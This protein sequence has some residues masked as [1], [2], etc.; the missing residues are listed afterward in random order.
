M[1]TRKGGKRVGDALYW[2]G[3]RTAALSALIN[4]AGQIAPSLLLARGG[5]GGAD[6]GRLLGE[7]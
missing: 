2:Q 7:V 5:Q 6:A 4:E 1:R 3:E